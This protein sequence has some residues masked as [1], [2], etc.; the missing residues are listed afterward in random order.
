MPPG[1][2]RPNRQVR[3]RAAATPIRPPSSCGVGLPP[4]GPAHPHDL[5]IKGALV[6]VLVDGPRPVGLHRV[7]W[8]G[9]SSAGLAVPSG[10]YVARL[11]TGDV[12]E[13][14]RLLLVK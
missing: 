1:S 10:V 2:A 11:E 4:E 5:H 8:D 7:R 14:R 3:E 9:L 12:R 6:R 13:T